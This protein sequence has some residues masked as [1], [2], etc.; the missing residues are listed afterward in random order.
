MAELST[1]I[2][3]EV[4]ESRPVSPFRPAG[5]NFLALAGLNAPVTSS[6]LKNEVFWR[7]TSGTWMCRHFR[8]LTAIENVSQVKI[9]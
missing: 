9:A 7:A 6:V 1:L 4:G 8:W 5:R 2:E 3:W